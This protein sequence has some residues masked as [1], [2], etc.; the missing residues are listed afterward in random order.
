MIY[1]N[2]HE[3]N[4]LELERDADTYEF[5]FEEAASDLATSQFSLV[6]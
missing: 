4:E 1:Y 5:L 2:D 6:Y 3:Q